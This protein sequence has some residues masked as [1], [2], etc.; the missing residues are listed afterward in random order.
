[1]KPSIYEEAAVLRV[2]TACKGADSGAEFFPALGKA[3]YVMAHCRNYK[4]FQIACHQLWIEPAILHKQI[5]FF[6]TAGDRVVGY[7]TW[8]YLAPEV[9]QRMMKDPNFLLHASEWRE[10]EN[11]WIMDLAAPFGY[12]RDILKVLGREVF[13]DVPQLKYIRRNAQGDIRKRVVMRNPFHRS[14]A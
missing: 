5:Q 3:A 12:T 10:G 1:M 2:R 9:E 11:V 4:L 13:P 6:Y 8:A 14:A 7:A